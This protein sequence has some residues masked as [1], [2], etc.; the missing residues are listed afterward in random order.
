MVCVDYGND[1]VGLSLEAFV[2]MCCFNI[3]IVILSKNNL[4]SRNGKKVYV[5]VYYYVVERR[6]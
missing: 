3:H 6:F 1:V 4:C 2:N 5:I